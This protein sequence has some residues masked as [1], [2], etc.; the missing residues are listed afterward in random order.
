MF[1]C[2]MR[3]VRLLLESLNTRASLVLE[4]AVAHSKQSEVYKI[5]CAVK[6]KDQNRG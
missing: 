1:L 6:E 2:A 5:A 3:C 4:I